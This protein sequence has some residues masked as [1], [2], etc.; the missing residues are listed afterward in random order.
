MSAFIDE[1][2]QF[3]DTD[4]KPIV[5]GL[6]YIGTNSLDPVANLITIYSD[7]ALSVPIANP[8]TLDSSGRSTNKIWIPGLYSFQVNNSS[9]VQKL[10]DLDAGETATTG[11]TILS[12]V[13][14]TNTITAVASPSISAYTDGQLYILQPA[15][16]NTGAVTINIDSLGATAI[17]ALGAALSGGELAAGLNNTI[18]YNSDNGN[19]DLTSVNTGSNASIQIFTSSGTWTKPAGVGSVRVVVIGGGGGGGGADGQGA[20]TGGSSAGGGSGGY[21]E[22][23]IDVTAISS[24]TVT[25][26]VGGG[27]GLGAAGNGDPGGNS[28]WSD[29]ANTLT[30]IGGAGATGRTGSASNAQYSGHLGGGATGGDLNVSGGTS[31][32]GF[33]GGVTY[34]NIRS[35]SGGGSFLGGEGLGV[36][37]F[38][39]ANAGIA[40]DTNSGSGGSGGATYGVATDATGGAGADGIVIVYEYAG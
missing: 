34:A 2:T 30:G 33:G 10:Q 40:G 21:S 31:E 35:G 17:N 14:G 5:N 13:Q 26:G 18:A 22:S 7:R 38:G 20:G 23:L 39:D 37:G 24:S 27:G 19:F 12:D 4:G 15:N 36:I 6:L 28:V 1:N 29:G 3:E 8:Q 32:G 25:V 16:D 11:T 9:A